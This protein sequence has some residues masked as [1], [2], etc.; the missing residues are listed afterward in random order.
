VKNQ[1][2]LTF[3]IISIAS[4]ILDENQYV[5][6]VDILLGLGYLS[7]NIL[8]DWYRGR[9]SYLENGLQVG[10]EKLGF[11]IQFFHEWANQ[12]GLVPREKN[13]I[14]KASTQTNYLMFSE[15][16]REEIEKYKAMG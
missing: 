5:S 10:S 4:R 3:K 12:Q 13:Y 1:Q 15:S 9:L 14:Q 2:Q 8:E 7:P 11:A 6:T 16:A